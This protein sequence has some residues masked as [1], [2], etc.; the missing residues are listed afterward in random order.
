MMQQSEPCYDV[1]VVGGGIV[2]LALAYIAAGKQQRV[3]LFER[4]PQALGATVRN[5]GMIWPIGQAAKGID[6]AMR[7]REIWLR[8]AQQAGF[9]AETWGSLHLAYEED[10]LHV[11]E[12]FVSG[13]GS[14]YS[15]RLLTPEETVARSTAVNPVGLEGAM[16]S[17]TEVNID[18][19]EAARALYHYLSKVLEVDI[20]YRTSITHVEYPYLGNENRTWQ[21]ERIFICT[22]ADLETLFPEM[23]S[24]SGLIKC[25]LQ[26]MRTSPQPE[27]YK[28]GPNLAGGLTLQ[29]YAS[30]AHCESLKLLK[31]RLAREM[32]AYNRWGIH[33][34]LSQT[35]LGE[36][37]IGDSHEYG[38]TPSPFDLQEINTLILRYL[39]KM[40]RM[41]NWEIAETWNGVYAKLPGKTAFVAE[42]QEQVW[43]VNGLGGAG[44]TLSFGL[45][46]ELVEKGVGIEL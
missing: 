42:P 4:H 29:H 24:R 40:A 46:E 13:A 32:E 12:E 25:K 18:P 27:G 3:I 1:A 19:R 5:F 16:F 41:P 7:S 36:L 45:A 35:R 33:V 10:E 38:D 15:C 34:M 37:T 8:L 31:E 43:V 2:G 6:R 26:M 20:R 44:M 30:F 23:F 21:A 28:L 11:L 9:W 22:G 17:E 39:K 14:P